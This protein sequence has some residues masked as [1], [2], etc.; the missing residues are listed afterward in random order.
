MAKKTK[1]EITEDSQEAL[2]LFKG[3]ADCAVLR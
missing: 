3:W 2:D 1:T